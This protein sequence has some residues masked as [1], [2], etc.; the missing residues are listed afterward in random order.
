MTASRNAMEALHATVAN[1]LADELTKDRE[2]DIPSSLL[3]AAIAFLKNN[4]IDAGAAPPGSPLG[5]LVDSLPFT[6]NEDH[7][8]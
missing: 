7:P 8:N 2:G 1:A 5:K 3:Q 6:T 4:G